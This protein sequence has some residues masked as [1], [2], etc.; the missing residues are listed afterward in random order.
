MQ[1]TGR[2][3][4]RALTLAF[5]AL[6][7]MALLATP[8]GAARRRV[9]VGFLGVDAGGVLV[10]PGLGDARLSSELAEMVRTGV[11]SVRIAI[12]WSLAQPYPNA[13]AVP[14]DQA[15]RYQPLDGIPTD[16]SLTD[17]VYRAAAAH[18]LQVLP[19]V[20][21]APIWARVDPRRA[22]SPP[23]DPATFGRFVGRA[24]QRYGP[25]GTFWR[26]HPELPAQPTRQW[27]IWN[28]PLGGIPGGPTVFWDDPGHAAEPRYVALLRSARTAIRA[29]DP[30][31]Q[32]VL[33]SLFGEAWRSLAD[34]YRFG[35]HGLFDVAAINLFTKLPND[36]VLGLK[37]TRSV[38]AHN[39]DRRLPVQ[40][41]EFS[42][43]TAKGHFPGYAVSSQ[44]AARNV[45]S[46]LS[47]LAH[48]RRIL[49]LQKV[50]YYT[51]LTPDSGHKLFDY[52]GMRRLNQRTLRITP[53]P[54]QA[55]YRAA[56]RQLEG[57]VKARLASVCGRARRARRR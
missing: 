35:V 33:A 31:G 53:K 54:A 6:L 9:P 36:E 21:A 48:T 15:F 34:L 20:L 7:L 56:A 40:L 3:A 22:W 26:A 4:R 24:V 8:A 39:G 46:A 43:P 45:G 17:R 5:V 44:Q 57:C 55:A 41:T 1:C 27:Q 50:F 19:T 10:D 42:W 49:N 52:A 11:E 47:K 37:Y 51:W 16:W 28:E 2:P 38:M 12:Y 13:A 29:A 25:G 32:V 18:G 23:A 30:H 14:A